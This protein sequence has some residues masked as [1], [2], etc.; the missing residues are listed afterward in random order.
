MHAPLPDKE[1]YYYTDAGLIVFKA[2]YHLKRGFCCGNRCRHCPYRHENVP[3]KQAE[4][5][6]RT[7]EKKR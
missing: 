1:D 4:N 7:P 5:V 6:R 3:S 2:S